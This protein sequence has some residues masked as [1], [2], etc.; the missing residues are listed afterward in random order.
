VRGNG[1]LDGPRSVRVEQLSTFA[2]EQAMD[3]FV[4]W[5]SEDHVHQIEVF[6]SEIVPTIR[7]DVEAKY[8]ST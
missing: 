6:A 7:E 5:P 4:C 2:L 1:L 8:S 3:T